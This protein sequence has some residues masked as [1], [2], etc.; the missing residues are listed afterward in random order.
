M[1]VMMLRQPLALE[2][3]APVSQAGTEMPK[4]CLQLYV[5]RN[6]GLT[7]VL[8]ERAYAAGFAALCLTVNAPVLRQWERDRRLHRCVTARSLLLVFALLVQGKKLVAFDRAR[9]PPPL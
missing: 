5:H 2:S 9:E 1:N 3:V 8:V 6:S 4:P 7:K